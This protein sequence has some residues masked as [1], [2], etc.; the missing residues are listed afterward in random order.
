M[1]FFEKI[2]IMCHSINEQ[3]RQISVV[4]GCTLATSARHNE[5]CVEEGPSDIGLMV[6]YPW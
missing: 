4:N 3:K 1:H 5:S 2:W 6:A